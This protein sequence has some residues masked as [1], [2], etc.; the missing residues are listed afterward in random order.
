MAF[1]PIR[2]MTAFLLAFAIS[3]LA[4][5]LISRLAKLPDVIEYVLFGFVTVGLY[6]LLEYR[7]RPRDDV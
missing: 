7:L 1:A 4:F 6:H 2:H 3:F 5:W